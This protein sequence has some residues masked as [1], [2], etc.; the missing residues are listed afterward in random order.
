MLYLGIDQ[1]GSVDSK[2]RPKPLPACILNGQ[3]FE[4]L[5]IPQFNS[6]HI[7]KI[8]GE[9][10]ICIDCVIGLPL[11]I[12]T[13]WRSA[14]TRTLEFHGYG[15][16]PAK[17]YFQSFLQKERPRRD[18][19]IQCQAN[20][21]FQEYPFQ[22]NIQTGTF[23]FWKEMAEDPDWFYAPFIQNEISKNRIPVFEGYPTLAWKILFETK[24]RE[25][26]LLKKHFKKF[27]PELRWNTKHQDLVDK[28]PNY[29]DAAVLA[30]AVREL[31]PKKPVTPSNE[32]WIL[33]ADLIQN[34]ELQ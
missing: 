2:G 29:A 25:P 26:S 16:N 34:E 24:K 17:N 5:E 23:R 18:V 31:Y 7:Q 10:S 11:S 30:L 13:P 4:L 20:S 27:Y 19:E 21:V 33:G 12:K 6:Q 1:T 3:D 14:I 9:L 8:D 32:G 28:N 22:K 15:R